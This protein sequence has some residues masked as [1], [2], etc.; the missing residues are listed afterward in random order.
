MALPLAVVKRTLIQQSQTPAT[1]DTNTNVKL[2]IVTILSIS[3]RLAIASLMK[4]RYIDCIESE[5]NLSS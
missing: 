4:L 3:E 1:R 2:T 5:E